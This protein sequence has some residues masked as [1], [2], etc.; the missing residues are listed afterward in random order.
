MCANNQGFYIRRSALDNSLDSAVT[1]VSHPSGKAELPRF[2][3]HVVAVA[4]AL[5][6]AGD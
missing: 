6:A 3:R 5:N 2:I 1:A 4:D